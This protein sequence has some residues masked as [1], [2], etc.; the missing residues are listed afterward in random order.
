M[1][2]AQFPSSFNWQTTSPTIGF[3]PAPGPNQDVAGNSPKSGVLAG[4]FTG[5]Q[6]LYTN[7]LGIQQMDNEGIEMT[8]T[9]TPT[10]TLSVMCSNSGVNFYALT[11]NPVLTQPSGAALGY[12]IQMAPVS[13]RY[14]FLQYVNASGSGT[15][16]A[17]SQCK[18]NNR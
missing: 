12:L 10:G 17:Y 4:A 8:W 7:I 3:L 6:T 13:F 15:I 18:A 16:T 9:G 5:V 2:K 11:F 1:G 14:V